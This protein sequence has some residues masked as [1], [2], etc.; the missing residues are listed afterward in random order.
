LGLIPLSQQLGLEIQRAENKH[1]YLA[2]VNIICAVVSIGVSALAIYLLPADYKIYG[3]FIGMAVSVI[4][5]AVI[6]SSVYYQ[7]QLSLPTKR[8]FFD[9]F[10]IG[11]IATLSWAIVFV[12]FRY[13][14]TLPTEW[15]RWWDT[16]IKGAS[17]LVIYGVLEYFGNRKQL[18]NVLS[19]KR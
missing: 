6:F 16:L 11:F 12:M 8:Y 18:K 13:A 3:P 15:N 5:G 4:V 7:K 1:K 9:F 2:I 10:K 14:I 19:K 17:F